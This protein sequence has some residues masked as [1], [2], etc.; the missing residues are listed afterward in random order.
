M[1]WSAE[2]YRRDYGGLNSLLRK[3]SSQ[4]ANASFLKKKKNPGGL[5]CSLLCWC[6]R[7]APPFLTSPLKL[8]A[9]YDHLWQR[10]SDVCLGTPRPRSWSWWLVERVSTQ[11]QY[12]P[13]RWV[14]RFL[15][16][17]LQEEQSGEDFEKAPKCKLSLFYFYWMTEFH[18]HE[19][20]SNLCWPRV[21]L[22]FLVFHTFLRLSS[23]HR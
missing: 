4:W 7:N 3:C 15:F 5:Q 22:L 14:L 9:F 2:W 11:S 17:W 6:N 8:K 19:F 23:A 1:S 21:I 16:V 12:R 13:L 18:S 20:T 10:T